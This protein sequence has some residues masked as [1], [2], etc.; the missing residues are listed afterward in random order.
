MIKLLLSL[1]AISLSSYAF[2]VESNDQHAPLVGCYESTAG[3]KDPIL[4]SKNGDGYTITINGKY[5]GEKAQIFKIAEGSKN[6]QSALVTSFKTSPKEDERAVINK[7]SQVV[8]RILYLS[9]SNSGVMFYEFTANA[10]KK[11]GTKYVLQTN[12]QYPYKKIDCRSQDAQSKK[13]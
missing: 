8:E 2:G 7:F 3:S 4:V 5:Y 6:I 9:D 13:Q 1:F 11:N 10:A 12:M